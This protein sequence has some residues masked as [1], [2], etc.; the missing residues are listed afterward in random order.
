MCVGLPRWGD[1]KPE[2]R[3][4]TDWENR[5]SRGTGEPTDKLQGRW[6]AS[7]GVW[8]GRGEKCLNEDRA[9]LNPH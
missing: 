6:G 7:S 5:T 4:L 1:L 3:N 8:G 9:A 2:G